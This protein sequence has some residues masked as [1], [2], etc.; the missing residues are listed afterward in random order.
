MARWPNITGTTAAW[1]CNAG[2]LDM[3]CFHNQYCCKDTRVVLVKWK[4]WRFM[5]LPRGCLT[6]DGGDKCPGEKKTKECSV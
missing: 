1:R 6:F 3:L 4:I 2:C 5:S